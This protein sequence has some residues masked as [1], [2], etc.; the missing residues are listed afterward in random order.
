[1]RSIDDQYESRLPPPPERVVVIA[2]LHRTGTTL[3]HRLLAA[4]GGVE[5]VRHLD[6]VEFPRLVHLYETGGLDA[7]AAQWNA[8]LAA[9]GPTRGIDDVP[10]G[11]LE[12]E[13]YGGVL[14]RSVVGLDRRRPYG[15]PD[16]RPLVRLARKKRH[17]AGPA[18]GTTRTSADR[19]LVLKNPI[20]CYDGLWRLDAAIPN[21]FF[22]IV[23]RHPLSAIRSAAASWTRLLAERN[24]WFAGLDRDYGRMHDIPGLIDSVRA[25]ARSEAYH[26]ELRD[27]YL[28]GVNHLLDVA[29]RLPPE[30]TISV[31]Y[32]DLC[33][34]P[35]VELDRLLRTLETR[36]RLEGAMPST[37]GII[38]SPTPRHDPVA[39]R[40]F[41]GS[42]ES[43]RPLLRRLGYADHPGGTT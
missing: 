18:S 30:R 36:V 42:I 23:H 38:A 17:L 24:H 12:P 35:D 31:R 4:T 43:W 7:V 2:G 11:A 6:V 5:V 39:E 40:M 27:R 15:N 20:D 3:L 14:R 19:P 8:T 25:H 13:E 32:E 29:S 16:L 1:M 21:A 22:I 33:A 10:I 41:E 34:T 26:S 9:H 37:E 28:V